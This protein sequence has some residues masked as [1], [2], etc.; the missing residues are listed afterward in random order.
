ME[1]VTDKVCLL[2]KDLKGRVFPGEPVGVKILNKSEPFDFDD[3]PFS[4]V[5]E[6][7]PEL[8]SL[9]DNE[10]S[11]RAKITET[12]SLLMSPRGSMSPTR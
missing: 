5:N 9:T 10:R 11:A 2:S 6:S 4:K 1:V 7:N 12:G 3:F 8:P